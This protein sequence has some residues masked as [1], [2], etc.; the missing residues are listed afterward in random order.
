MKVVVT[1]AAGYIGGQT[2]LNL[3]DQGHE[4]LGIDN[5]IPPKHLLK[6]PGV[7]WHT[8]DYATEL[9]FAGIHQFQPDAIIHCAGT[10]LVGPSVTDPA[11]Y[12]ENN[13][14]KTK[15]LLDFLIVNGMTSTRIIFS[16]SAATYG[17]PVMT[18][19]QEIDP[20]EPIS[21]YGQSKLMI[22]WMLSSYG[23]AYGIDSVA[24][25]YFNACGA[26]SRARHG[27]EPGAT[28]IIARVLESV[29]D[30]TICTL[31]GTDYP[32][33]DGT[34][35]RDY[36]H[37]EDLA[38]AHIRAMDR[39]IPAGVYNLGTNTGHSNLEVITTAATVTKIAI[40]HKNG[41]RRAG[42]P[43]MLTADAGKFMAAGNWQPQWGL[44]DIISHAWAWYNR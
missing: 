7:W 10:S 37:V 13:F 3:V 4:V 15:K 22:E 29:R 31:Y 30:G 14:V 19:C 12:Y 32:T 25:R 6:I 27:Q 1:G 26:D 35:I 5:R 21:P 8:G 17:E 28:H 38:D 24:F 33:P 20:A 39:A 34:C 41:P 11:T 9:A 42:D 36:I 40:T 18:P 44:E 16:S 2:L 23:Q 43:A